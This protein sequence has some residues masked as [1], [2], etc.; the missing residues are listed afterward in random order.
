MYRV[1]YAGTGGWVI[2]SALTQRSGGSTSTGRIYP[3]RG[4]YK[5]GYEP[6]EWTFYDQRHKGYDVCSSSGDRR[7]FAPFSGRVIRG[8]ISYTLTGNS[9]RD[10]LL[11]LVDLQVPNGAYVSRGQYL[12]TYAQVGVS[13]GRHLHWER[14]YLR[15]GSWVL[16]SSGS[17]YGL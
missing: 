11:H 17:A 4:I 3:V 13:R 12:G 16:Q 15:N 7:V 5:C 1:T 8:E 6:G 10:K 14:Y 2:G 9:V